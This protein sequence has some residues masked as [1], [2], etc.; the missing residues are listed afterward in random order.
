M[1]NLSAFHLYTFPCKVVSSVKIRNIVEPF[2]ISAVN[3]RGKGRAAILRSKPIGLIAFGALLSF[4]AGCLFSFELKV[5]LVED[6]I[7]VGHRAS[8]NAV[9]L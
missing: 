5:S 7:Q 6:G 1:L 4:G 9:Y 3:H 8:G 2:R